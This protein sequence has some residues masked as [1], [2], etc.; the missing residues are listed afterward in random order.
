MKRDSIFYKLFKQLPGILFELI[1]QAPAEADSATQTLRERYRFDS[2]EVKETAF[3]IDGVFLPPDDA[4][5]KVIFFSEV[6]FQKDEN[7]YKRC[8][9][10]IFLYLRR[11]EVAYDDWGAVLIFGSR[12]M[13]PS[14]S[15]WYRSL[16]AG[17]QIFRIYL[18]EIDNWREQPLAIGVALLTTATDAETPERARYLLNRGEQIGRQ[19]DI[20]ELISTI[21]VYKF[22]TLGWEAVAV[23]LN[24]QDVRLEDTRAY[25]E[26]A[27]KQGSA[28]RVTIALTQLRELVGDLPEVVEAQVA[29]LTLVQLEGLSKAL[30][31]FQQLSDLE[32]WLTANL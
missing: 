25:Q 26:I 17:S 12:S 10:E 30:L 4:D 5:S 22:P 24:I 11:S 9:A 13:E 7:L 2:V 23:M 32:S 31:R 19:S 16:L 18:D 3:R 15:T 14:S 27:E 29:T 20:L 6:Q 21:M 28:V 8:F 1:D